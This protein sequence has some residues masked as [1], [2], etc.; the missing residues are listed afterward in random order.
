MS[1]KKRLIEQKRK[2]EALKKA[3]RNQAIVRMVGI[4]IIF[5]IIAIIAGALIFDAA[6]KAEKELNYSI[7][8]NEDGKIKGVNALK[9][10]ELCDFNALNMNAAD[11]YPSKEDEEQ[12]IAGITE[13]YPDL[14]DKKG[15]EVK[16]KDMVNIDYV[17]TIDG[18]EYEGGNTNKKGIALTL[19]VGNYPTDFE[20]GIIGHKTGETF[21]ITVD[22]DADFANEEL[23][24]KSVNYEIT[25]N[26]VF[27]PAEFNDA[28]VAKNFGASAENAE[29]FLNKYRTN[30]A[31]GEFDTYVKSFIITDST[32]KSFP[33][34][35]LSKMKKYMK[36][37]DYK[38]M[39][40]S[41][42]TYQNLYGYDAYKDVLEMRGMDKE[43]YA[44]ATKEAAEIEAKKNLV[45][46]AL[47][48]KFNLSVSDDDL[49]AVAS[50]YGFGDDDYE[51]AVDRFGNPYIHQQA[52]INV[53]NDY[54]AENY[55]LAE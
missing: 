40:T 50:S 11:F 38:Q 12:Y 54:L 19:G 29:D 47:Y 24:G 28:F 44:K 18:L 14:S 3:E 32:V 25:I 37:K 9:Y 53:V 10:V 5:L 4:V 35:Y 8:L 26:G 45:Y 27:V 41:N 51:G 52:I 15:V 55:N 17:G 1:R 6:K 33:V 22:Y 46:Q 39:E 34:S 43:E 30:Y 16:E 36:A 7:G 20:N 21:D 31:Q 48:E 49:K 42:A 13:S 2:A 23:A